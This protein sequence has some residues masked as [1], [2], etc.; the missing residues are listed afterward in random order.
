MQKTRVLAVAA[1]VALT[2]PALA[3]SGPG[4]NPEEWKAMREATFAEADANGDGALSPDEFATFKEQVH[5]KRAERRFQR[6]DAD[7]NGAVTLAELEAMPR[8]GHKKGGC[9]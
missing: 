9:R 7:G 5:R 4:G 8:H 2:L 1:A 3:W 6:A